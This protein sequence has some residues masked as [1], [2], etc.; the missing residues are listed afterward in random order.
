M[1]Q[2]RVAPA[3]PARAASKRQPKP[4]P[5]KRYRLADVSAFPTENGY[6]YEII[7]GELIVTPA[8]ARPHGIIASRIAYAMTGFF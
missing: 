8:P 2:A 6:R 5:A 1:T 3:P 7:D 4:L